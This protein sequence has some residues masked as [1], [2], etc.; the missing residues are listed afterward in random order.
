MELTNR[1]DLPQSLVRAVEADDY[2]KGDADF[3]V[4]ELIGPPRIAVLKKV[5]EKLVSRDVVDCIPSLLGRALHKIAEWGARE[6]EIVEERFFHEIDGRRISGA[7][8]LQTP[9]S[10]GK[11]GLRDFK[12]TS[13]YSATA[14]KWEWEA[15]LNIYRWLA[16]VTKQREVT[17]LQIIAIM[18]DWSRK[19]A[20]FEPDY[21]TH[22]V[23][24]QDIPLWDYD[25]IEDYVRERVALH[26]KAHAALDT[27]EPVDYC[28]PEER[29]LRGEKWAVLKDGQKRAKRV[30]ENEQDANDFLPDEEHYVEHRPGNPIRCEGDYCLVARWCGQW[31]DESAPED[32]E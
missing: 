22:Q 21:P 4:T 25:E 3:S 7:A 17:R 12:V 32:T 23:L 14:E 2:S 15:Q 5:N 24:V 28:T 31:L 27:G 16:F 8:D 10:N 29:W 30:F 1:F 19:K 11:W 18:K 20:M 26:K 6:D 9:L 13:V